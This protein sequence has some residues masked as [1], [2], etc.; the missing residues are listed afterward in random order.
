MKFNEFLNS[1]EGHKIEYIAFCLS[2]LIQPKTT[3]LIFFELKFF[4]YP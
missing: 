2:Y 1:Q 3:I 4:R